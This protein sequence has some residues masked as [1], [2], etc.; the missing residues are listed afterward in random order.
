M[1]AALWNLIN[2]LGWYYW[3]PFIFVAVHNVY[4]LSCLSAPATALG[5]AART[6]AWLAH[7]PLLFAPFFN[8]MGSLALPLMLVANNLLYRQLRQ[9]CVAAKPSANGEH[10]S[11][12]IL[13]TLVAKP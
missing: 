7:I 4:L 8:V 9:A 12:Q 13:N 3:L 2:W 1:N 11:R 5:R 6:F 10:L